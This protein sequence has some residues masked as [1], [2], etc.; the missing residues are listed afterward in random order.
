MFE[1]LGLI[2]LNCLIM[3]IPWLLMFLFNRGMAKWPVFWSQSFA[4]HSIFFIL[5]EWV[6]ANLGVGGILIADSSTIHACKCRY[7]L[8]NGNHYFSPYTKSD[9]ILQYF[10][11]VKKILIH[12][13]GDFNIPNFDWVRSLS[14]QNC[15][16]YFKWKG[17]VVYTST[18][19]LGLTQYASVLFPAL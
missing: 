3:F 17:D 5:I 1:L 10:T 4:W 11:Y 18:Y 19:F 13:A 7:S 12:K 8:H 9:I 2:K 15:Y 6:S 14:L 16:F